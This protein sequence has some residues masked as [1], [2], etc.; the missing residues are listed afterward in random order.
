MKG[1]KSVITAL[2]ITFIWS[3]LI[4]G[5]FV[6]AG[7]EKTNNSNYNYGE[8]LQK[9]IMFYEFQRSGKL[10][11]DKR[12]N[13]RADSGMNDGADVGLDLTGGWYDAGDHVK[14][15][16]PMSY[17]AAMLAWSVYE[18]KDA[19]EKSGQ[20]TYIMNAIKWAD[21]YLI[22]CHPEKDVYY[23]QVGDAEAD[24][25]WWG[26]SEV[27]QMERPAYK[28]DKDN[29]GS[30]VCAQT[31]ATLASSAIIFKDTDPEYSDL[32]LKH[33]EE[34]F[35]FADETRSNK[36]YTKAD[37]YYRLGGSGFW[38]DLSWASA[39]L[40][41]ATDNSDY[42][43][44]SESYVQNWTTEQ[45]TST[46]SY[47][48]G[49]CWDDVH[50]GA[51]LL[52]ARITNKDIY[53]ES[54]ERNFDWW[55]TGYDDGNGIQRIRY[56]DK[57]LAFLDTWGS[58]RY[59]EA[60]AFLAQVYAEWDGCPKDKA[61][62][63][64]SFMESQVNYALGS[65]GRSFEV[66]FGENY[67]KNIHH[68]DG[69]ASW[70][71]DKKV[72]GYARHIVYGA[73]AGGPTSTNDNSYED[74]VS[75]FNCNEPACDYNAGFVA[76]LAKMY[77]KYGGEPIENFKSIEEKTNDEFYTEDAVN[78]LGNNF[79][80]I[81]ALLYNKSGWPAKV[82]DKLSF[83]YFIDLSELYD[84][85]YTVE[86]TSVTT[87]YNDGAKVSQLIPWNE[88]KHIYYVNADFTGTKI[89]PGGQSAYRKEV[90]F[91]ISGPKDTN[92]WDNSNDYSYEEIEKTPGE[93]PIQTSKIPV[94]D[95]GKLVYGVE[96]E[97]TFDKKDETERDIVLGDIS[98]DGKITLGD[99][100]LLRRYISS[101]DERIKIN[102][103]NSDINKDGIV[104][105]FD[106][107]A[108]KYLI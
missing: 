44:K 93:K 26:P 76:A 88:G 22:K 21:D 40:Y 24:H 4:P 28:V 84:A 92:F 6:D 91:R 65:T 2:I 63:Y 68:R 29:P 55:T 56:T 73:L 77:K 96:P 105:F 58:L 81:K 97:K 103:K 20:L 38:D 39:W 18:D 42:L 90:Q 64:K 35:E 8:A 23:Y 78:A 102:E 100:T 87:N 85:G 79:I 66:G 15:N 59:A 11:E 86:D 1:R 48:W 12:D 43:R 32:C 34:L 71:D 98:G 5:T 60:T 104:D 62:T 27:M 61:E 30:S 7:E 70:L 82:G 19:Y 47:K 50:Y 57:G 25:K 107:I 16:L 80:E 74:N 106:L 108:L 72:P 31:A 14:F 36:G 89:Y 83:K 99:Y 45:Q 9:A 53:K 49:Q 67:P 52:L 101:G 54:C 17:S 69:Q 95:D 13:W 3:F 33:A 51:Q 46:I 10:P 37:G 41:L 94:Y 75:N